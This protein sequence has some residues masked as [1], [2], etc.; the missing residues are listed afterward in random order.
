MPTAH[1]ILCIHSTVSHLV[2]SAYLLTAN[3]ATCGYMDA[4]EPLVQVFWCMGT[5]GMLGYTVLNLGDML[6]TSP[7]DSAIS[8]A[9]HL[10]KLPQILY[11]VI[12]GDRTT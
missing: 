6:Y 4:H 11:I 1:S 7:S 8:P 12:A 5:V 2:L 10:H 3:R 9:Q